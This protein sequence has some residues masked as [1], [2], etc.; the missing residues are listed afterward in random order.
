MQGLVGVLR[1]RLEGFTL[2]L[3]RDKRIPL[4]DRKSL[5]YEEY[6]RRYRKIMA[7]Q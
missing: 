2:L 3:S 4:L 5:T 6:R 7:A 1:N